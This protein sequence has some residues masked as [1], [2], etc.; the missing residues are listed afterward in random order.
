MEVHTAIWTQSLLALHRMTG[1]PIY[2]TKA[3]NASNTIM[4]TQQANGAYSTWGY[5]LRF[6]RPLLAIDWPGCNA[7]ALLGLLRMS[8]YVGSL[9][10]S[11][12][13]SQPL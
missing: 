11:R 4:R 2:L 8:R 12:E 13:E 10:R 6:G 7:I 5:D 3:I 9:P 1:K